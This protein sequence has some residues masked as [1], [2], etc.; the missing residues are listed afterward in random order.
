MNNG[1][2]HKTGAFD[3]TNGNDLAQ[4]RSGVNRWGTTPDQRGRYVK[5]LD[6]ALELSIENGDFRTINNIVKTMV[7][8]EGQVQADE[9]LL[10]RL[11]AGGLTMADDQTIEVR[12]IRGDRRGLSDHIDTDDDDD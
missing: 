8:I 6:A 3:M 10:A 4:L 7:L 2:G 11:T 12:V 1:N 9:H 5:A